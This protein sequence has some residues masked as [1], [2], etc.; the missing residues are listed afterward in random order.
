MLS[1]WIF[2]TNWQLNHKTGRCDTTFHL[3]ICNDFPYFVMNALNDKSK[4][5][6]DFGFKRLLTFTLR[7]L[8]NYHLVL[9]STLIIGRINKRRSFNYAITIDRLINKVFSD[10]LCTNLLSMRI[11]IHKWHLLLVYHDLHLGSF[12]S[13]DCRFCCV[14]E[15]TADAL[16]Y[17]FCWFTLGLTRDAIKILH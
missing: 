15:T 14:H 2:H 8:N 4:A 17:C 7:L 10:F 6:L 11:S 9:F 12:S 13:F 5:S 3:F 1:S 16:V